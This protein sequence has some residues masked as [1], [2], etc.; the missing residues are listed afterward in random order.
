MLRIQDIRIN[1]S[2][3]IKRFEFDGFAFEKKHL[4][5]HVRLHNDKICSSFGHADDTH[6]MVSAR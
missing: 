2:V 3:N 1:N 5:H 4:H 6:C